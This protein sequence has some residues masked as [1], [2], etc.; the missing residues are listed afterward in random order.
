MIDVLA[1]RSVALANCSPCA[2]FA[3]RKVAVHTLTMLRG[4]ARASAGWAIWAPD[5]RYRSGYRCGSEREYERHIQ[6]MRAKGRTVYQR[7]VRMKTPANGVTG[8]RAADDLSSSAS[9]S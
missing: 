2:C 7:C 4:G 3:C 9:T 6:A 5:Q 8:P 1:S